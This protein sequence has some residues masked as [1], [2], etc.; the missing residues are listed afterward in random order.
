M[1]LLFSQSLFMHRDIEAACKKQTL[2]V[3][4]KSKEIKLAATGNCGL[5]LI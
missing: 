2:N 1:R 3:D 5:Q 4:G